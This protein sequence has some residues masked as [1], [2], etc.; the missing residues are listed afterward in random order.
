MSN[1]E[2]IDWSNIRFA[3][4]RTDSRFTAHYRHGAWTAGELTDDD[5]LTLPDSSPVLHYGQGVFEGMKALRCRNGAVHVFRA[6]H[7]YQRLCRSTDR[8]LM[9]R[10]PEPLFF[11]SLERLLA[12]NTRWIP[13]YESGCSLYIRPFLIGVGE[14]IG[15][16]PAPEY[17]YR[18]FC[19]PVGAYYRG[20]RFLL[21]L[22]PFDRCPPHGTGAVKTISNYAAG[23][24]P[25]KEAADAGASE[26][27]YLD[28]IE[29]RYVLETNTS[30]LLFLLKS[31]ELV[32]PEFEE[33]IL[34]SI[35]QDSILT[36][37]REELAIPVSKRRFD[38]W[39]ER[40]EILEAG[41]CG[42]AA[43]L[44]P[45]DRIAGDDWEMSMGSGKDGSAM[46]R[47]RELLVQ[48]QKGDH[49]APD[50]WLYPVS[51]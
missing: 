51:M 4:I 21:R 14:N 18:V 12:A 44:T 7:S 6:R 48:I 45:V 15:V 19:V 9:P 30:N 43:G 22:T 33:C 29:R 35:T 1:R 24:L 20:G 39:A 40:D 46:M 37:A 50:G 28:P 25:K 42:T 2:E 3:Y 32:A 27:L 38:F 41:A 47:L 5:G 17:I 31:G 8:V 16:V 36:I 10:V 26:V 23:L 49:P 13:P 34:P 11:E